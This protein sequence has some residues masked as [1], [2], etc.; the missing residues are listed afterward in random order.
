MIFYQLCADMSICPRASGLSIVRLPLGVL[1]LHVAESCHGA[2]QLLPQGCTVTSL[3]SLVHQH[4]RRQHLH[5]HQQLRVGQRP[6]QEQD[7]LSTSKDKMLTPLCLTIVFPCVIIMK[8]IINFP[9]CAH[10]EMD[11][12]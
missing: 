2:G 9:F 1:I 7:I 5:S 6:L 11:P 3:H 8:N 10:L 4:H 12:I